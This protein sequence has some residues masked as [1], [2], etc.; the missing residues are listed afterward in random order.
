MPQAET[1]AFQAETKELLDLVVHSLYT[2]EEIFLRELI[3]NASDALDKLRFASLK[4]RD[5]EADVSGLKIRLVPD[6]EQ[7]VLQVIDNGIGMSRQEL[8]DNIGTIARSGTKEFLAGLRRAKE[9][10]SALPELPQLIGQFGVGFYSSFMVAEEVELETR[11]AGESKGLRWRSRGDGAYTLEEIDKPELGTTVTLHLKRAAPDEPDARDYTQESVLREL[12][13]RYSD[14]IAYP[15][16]LEIQSEQEKGGKRVEVLN[17]QKPLWARPKEGIEPKEYAEFYR[18]LSHDWREPLE[19]IHLRAEGAHEY[20]ALLYLP[21]ERPFDLF[22]PTQPRSRVHL[23]VKR[24][25]IMAD[26]E[27]LAPPWLRFVRGIVDS[28]DLPLNVSR[29]M[30]QRSR[31]TAQIKKRIVRKVLDTFADLLEK[32]RDDYAGFWRAFGP[33]IKE[34]LYFDDESRAE[35]AEIALFASSQGPEPTT[36][37][38]YVAR[39]PVKQRDIY[40]LLANDLETARRSPHLEAFKKEGFE[41]L[42]FADPVDEFVLQRLTSFQEKKIVRADQGAIDL[43]DE[44]GKKERAAKE[45]ELGDVLEAVRKELAGEV[46]AVRF[47]SRLTE[48]PACL[49]AGEHGLSPAMRRLLREAGQ[50]APDEKPVLELN[51]THPLIARLFELSQ[52]PEEV[53][54]FADACQVLAG[55]ARVSAGE[56]PK[57]PGGFA[58]LVAQAF[59]RAD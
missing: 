59:A 21:K 4:N 5:L 15:I 6:P 22:D 29:E 26:C 55:L 42:L 20:T 16:E 43:G 54:R 2:N 58:R 48:S 7:R 44:E 37:A 36:L 10:A 3:S 27:E 41:V 1:F 34:G 53:P 28:A 52:K 30:L 19:T 12:V 35:I 45:K 25:F 49:V 38:E 31:Q 51:A 11:R 56:V 39:M 8:I 47:S 13:R 33:I 32:R 24:V 14:F 17:S 50:D 18:H 23:Y 40:V 57:D 9:E 46:E